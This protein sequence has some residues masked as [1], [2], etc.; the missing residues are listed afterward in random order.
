MIIGCEH[1]TCPLRPL[2]STSK[3][4]SHCSHL[5]PLPASEFH[6]RLSTLGESLTAFSP[7]SYIAEPNVSSSHLPLSE[8]LYCWT[9]DEIPYEQLP[10]IKGTV[11][12]DGSIRHFIFDGLRTTFPK[13]TVI[14]APTE[15]RQLRER[16]S[17]GELELSKCANEATLLAI[18]HTHKH[19]HVGIRESE[20]RQLVVRTLNDT[21]LK[22][23][24]CPTLFGG[25]RL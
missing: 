20:A 13:P 3:I 25:T 19:T 23:G 11:F 21:G 4:S 5:G 8:R 18:R 16:K 1:P 12:V 24:G 7:S 10:G 14:A 15:I 9:E 2:E 17:E 6:A 22:D